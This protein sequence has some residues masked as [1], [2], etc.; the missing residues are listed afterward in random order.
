MEELSDRLRD[1]NVSGAEAVGPLA[2]GM[3]EVN[4]Q[5]PSREPSPARTAPV[6]SPTGLERQVTSP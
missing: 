3:A 5:D 1:L 4:I 2:E 6:L